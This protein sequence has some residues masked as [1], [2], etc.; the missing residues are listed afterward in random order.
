MACGC[1]CS[2]TGAA[3]VLDGYCL[4]RVWVEREEPP[5]LEEVGVCVLNDQVV[6]RPTSPADGGQGSVSRHK[7]TQYALVAV[8]LYAGVV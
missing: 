3:P 4:V 5:F 6:Y 8:G 7:S 1:A 2:R